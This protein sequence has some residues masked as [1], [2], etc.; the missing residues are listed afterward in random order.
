[1]PYSC[2]VRSTWHAL[3]YTKPNLSMWGFTMPK[4]FGIG[5]HI[6][7][8]PGTF[9]LARTFGHTVC[10]TLCSRGSAASSINPYESVPG[11]GRTT[12]SVISSEARADGSRDSRNRQRKKNNDGSGEARKSA[13]AR[14]RSMGAVEAAER[15]MGSRERNRNR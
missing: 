13:Y 10:T 5:Q 6:R 15:G 9:V 2:K 12:S 1:M 7:E 4:G 14:S 8:I 11:G 3:L